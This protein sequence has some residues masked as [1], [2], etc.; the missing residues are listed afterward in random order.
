MLRILSMQIPYNYK[1]TVSAERLF[2]DNGCFIFEIEA[3]IL[4][5]AEFSGE[6]ILYAPV[7]TLAKGTVFLKYQDIVEIC[8][9]YISK[10]YENSD[11]GTEREWRDFCETLLDIKGIRDL[12][13]GEEI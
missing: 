6:R 4:W 11:F 12:I 1:P 5:W 3:P 7:S 8:E 2:E 10:Q 13:F 9:D